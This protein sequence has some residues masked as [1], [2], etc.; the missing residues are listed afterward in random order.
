M[1]RAEWLTCED[2][3]P[4]VRSL[5]AD[6]YQ[7]ELRLFTLACVRRVWEHLP[8]AKLRAAVEM[9]ERYAHERAG[10]FQ[11]SRAVEAANKVFWDMYPRH[12]APGAADYAASAAIDASSVWPKTATNVLAATSAAASAAA[13]AAA[14]AVDD[15]RYDDKF[16]EAHR[17]ELAAQARLLR[18]LIGAPP[19]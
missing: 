12:S 15:S 16:H 1:T 17:A 8:H 2:P 6:R 4:M 3:D 10:E 9:S 11:L 5:P 13:C 14:E 18:G 19:T 7:K